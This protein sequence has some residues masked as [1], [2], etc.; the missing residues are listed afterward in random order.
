MILLR[1]S[2]LS[3]FSKFYLVRFE[4]V[5]FEIW[6]STATLSLIDLSHAIRDLISVCQVAKMS[7]LAYMQVPNAADS[8][9]F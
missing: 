5:S 9:E 2:I 1:S 7:Y 4:N 6:N 8:A 3:Y